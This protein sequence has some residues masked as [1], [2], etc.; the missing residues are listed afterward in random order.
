M[1]VDAVM[2]VMLPMPTSRQTGKATATVGTKVSTAIIVP[3]AMADHG[4]HPHG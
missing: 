4:H 3:K 1:A 2:K